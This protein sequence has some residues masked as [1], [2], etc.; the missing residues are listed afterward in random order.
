M[1]RC[2]ENTRNAGNFDMSNGSLIMAPQ[3]PKW[4]F[5]AVFWRLTELFTT[6]GGGNG[7]IFGYVGPFGMGNNRTAGNLDTTNGSLITHV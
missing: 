7:E 1:L 5:L 6:L 3:S 2:L 4:P